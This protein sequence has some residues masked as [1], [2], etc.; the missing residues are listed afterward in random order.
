MKEEKTAGIPLRSEVAEKD[1]WNLSKLYIS[2]AG[3]EDAFK[4]FSGRAAAMEKFKGRLADSADTFSACLETI[5]RDSMDLERLGTYAQLRLSEDAGDDANQKRMALFAGLATRYET[6]S[7]FFTPELQAIPEDK[8]TAFRKDPRVA[9][10]SIMLDKILRFRPHILSDAEERL[11]AM[12]GESDQTPSKTFGALTNVDFDFG[13]IDTPEGPRPLSQ[14]AYAFF[15]QN[16]D[17]GIR[18]K[19]YRQ[20]YGVFDS[21][22]NTLASL[23][24]G[25]I[26]LD[27]YKARAR[28]YPSA[29]AMALFPDKVPEEVY[30]NLVSTIHEFFPALHRYYALRKKVLG[31]PELRHYDVYVPLVKG[32]TTR[33]PYE[34]AAQVIADAVVPLGADYRDTIRNGLL[35]GWVD[36]YE[37]KGKRAGA[38]SSGAY[39]ADPY[40][41]MNYKED[42]LSDLFTLIHEGGHSMHSHYSMANNPFQHYE[43]TIFEAEVASTFN[44]QLLADH[45]LKRADSRE[46]KAFII[47]KLVDDTIATIFR[48]TMFAEF[49]HRCHRIVEEENPLSTDVF[50]QEYRKLLEAYFGPEMVFEEESDLEG[51]RIPHFYRAFYVYKYATGL[52]AAISLAQ[53]VLNG[54]AAERDAYLAFLRSGGSRYPIESLALAGVDMSSPEPIREALNRFMEMTAEL[55][56]LLEAGA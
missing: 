41:L 24:E 55:E 50:R 35:S 15:M 28:K 52:S 56:G 7:S 32:V 36:R 4:G 25:S 47:G 22:R 26:H 21:H 37:N 20:F 53:R 1:K 11:L 3:W 49:E 16:P 8:I 2:E 9:P 10:Y 6:A 13:S 48:Q 43:Y 14:A 40:I 34:E 54:G 38:F 45:L 12:T 29:R 23:Y 18:E 33:Y 5:T 44:E 39:G 30:D 17:R 46:M 19:A 31:V 27:I 51:L 42:V